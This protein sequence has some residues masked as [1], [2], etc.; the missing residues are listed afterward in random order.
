MYLPVVAAQ[1]T[2]MHE[3]VLSFHL[4]QKEEDILTGLIHKT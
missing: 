2:E 4:H 1:I 3:G